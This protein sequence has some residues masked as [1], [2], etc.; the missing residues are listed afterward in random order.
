MNLPP[1]F[2]LALL[3]LLTVLPSRAETAVR[4]SVSAIAEGL[5]LSDIDEGE[6]VPDPYRAYGFSAGSGH[7]VTISVSE[8]PAWYLKAATMRAVSA[9]G[10]TTNR[11]ESLAFGVGTQDHPSVGAPWFYGR[12]SLGAGGC[13]FTSSGREK[14]KYY[15]LGELN[16]ELGAELSPHLTVGVGLSWQVIGYPTETVANSLI[17]KAVLTLGF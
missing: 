4:L 17:P 3:A 12:I 11:F 8:E 5:V 2:C 7:E 16:G 15:A 13:R 9:A 14:P 1:R 10:E 6:L